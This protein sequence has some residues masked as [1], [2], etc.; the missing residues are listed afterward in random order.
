M[1][2]NY[3]GSSPTLQT[4][5][6]TDYDESTTLQGA[7]LDIKRSKRISFGNNLASDLSGLVFQRRKS[8]FRIKQHFQVNKI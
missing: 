2:Y 7:T 5:L 6:W 8:R 1:K 4:D 3:S